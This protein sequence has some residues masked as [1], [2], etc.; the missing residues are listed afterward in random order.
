MVADA[1]SAGVRKAAAS[2]RPNKGPAGAVIRSVS[3]DDAEGAFADEGGS[4]P[5]GEHPVRR[6]KEPGGTGSVAGVRLGTPDAGG[7]M[8]TRTAQIAAE[9][10]ARRRGQQQA[11]PVPK[12]PVAPALAAIPPEVED[13][14]RDLVAPAQTPP[15]AQAAPPEPAPASGDDMLAQATKQALTIL[16]LLPVGTELY[17]GQNGLDRAAGNLMLGVGL[18]IGKGYAVY[19]GDS[20][21]RLNDNGRAFYA[22]NRGKL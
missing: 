14:E 18:L 5:H 2:G 6:S 16:G 9:K 10:A 7:G 1:L 3:L 21:Y 17:I 12:T 4:I 19:R 11:T 8:D 20:H 15:V 13:W 22:A